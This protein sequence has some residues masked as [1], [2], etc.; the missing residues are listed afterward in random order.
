MVRLGAKSCFIGWASRLLTSAL[1]VSST[2]AFAQGAIEALVAD[3]CSECHGRNGI[4]AKS[5]VPH[6]DGQPED[7]LAN[8]ISSFREG[9]RPTQVQAHREVTTIEIAALAKHY[10]LQKVQRPMAETKAELIGRG[11]VLYLK[12]CSQCHLDNGRDSDKGAPHMAAQNPDYLFSQMK[13]F[14]SGERKFPFLM[15]EA[16]K[17]LSEDDFAAIAVFFAAQEQVAPEQKRRRRR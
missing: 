15:D 13:A 14:R 1:L 11:E 3:K 10:S 7:I 8:M 17:N 9:K 4:S 6:V 12:R 5:G 2:A 16:Y